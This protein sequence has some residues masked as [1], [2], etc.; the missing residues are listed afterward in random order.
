MPVV[1]GS[2]GLRARDNGEWGADKLAFISHFAPVAL[3]ATQNVPQRHYIDLFAGPGLNRVRNS[4][5]EFEGSPLRIIKTV[6]DR[7]PER[8]FTHAWFVNYS[9]KDHEA[10]RIRITRDVEAGRSRIPI[11]RIKCICGDSNREVFRIL[12]AIPSR[13]FI[14]AFADMEAPK[15]CHWTTISALRTHRGHASV[16]LYILFPLEMAIARLISRREETV[17]LSSLAL[18]NFY[19]D[20]RWRSLLRYRKT[21]STWNSQA[22]RQDALRIYMDRLRE[23]WK[24]VDVAA[25]IRR[26]TRHRLYKMIF[27]T[28][29]QAGKRIATWAKTRSPDQGALLL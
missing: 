9:K 25:D 2:D 12:D 11:E 16:D 18:D 6:S 26:G 14:F 4:N 5:E 22:L 8:Y 3:T 20:D 1:T 28:N 13:S 21:D 24:Y 19:G 7:A 15:Q 17:E 27:A 29:H 10:L 23:H